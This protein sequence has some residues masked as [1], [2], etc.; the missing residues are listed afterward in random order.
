MC[1]TSSL[2]VLP[3]KGYQQFITV[4]F[5]ET[6][7]TIHRRSDT[8]G[9]TD[10]SFSIWG[11]MPRIEAVLTL[12]ELFVGEKRNRLLANLFNNILGFRNNY[13]ANTARTAS[14]VD[15][16]KNVGVSFKNNLI[17]IFSIFENLLS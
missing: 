1:V 4:Y 17:L 14:Q 5:R 13:I 15:Q 12:S 16:F 11:R 9:I 2:Q 8:I 6:T 7:G 10:C 3:C